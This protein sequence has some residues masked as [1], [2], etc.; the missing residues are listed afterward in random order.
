[1]P[2]LLEIDRAMWTEANAAVVEDTVASEQYI[3]KAEEKKAKPTTATTGWTDLDYDQR[4]KELQDVNAKMKAAIAEFNK[5]KDEQVSRCGD[6]EKMME[7]KNEENF[8]LKEQMKTIQEKLKHAEM[9]R[10]QEREKKMEIQK[11][12]ETEMEQLQKKHAEE[13]PEKRVKDLVEHFDTGE[14]DM[15]KRLDIEK[16]L[17]NKRADLVAMKLKNIEQSTLLAAAAEGNPRALKELGLPVLR[18]VG[19]EE[20]R[21]SN[22]P[23]PMMKARPPAGPPPA[24]PPPPARPAPRMEAGVPARVELFAIST[25]MLMSPRTKRP[26]H[27]AAQV[28]EP[29]LGLGGGSAGLE[30]KERKVTQEMFTYVMEQMREHLGGGFHQTSGGDGGNY[31]EGHLDQYRVKNAKGGDVTLTVVMMLKDAGKCTTN[32]ATYRAFKAK[33]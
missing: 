3:D 24:P 33:I 1:M 31:F 5:A 20:A 17:E 11:K 29:W 12:L 4:E 32:S 6:Y 14:L 13:E 18:A 9:L 28:V 26:L 10:E 22:D 30:V 25:P 15:K 16:E 2:S 8:D 21:G 19:A 27:E 23:P 7:I